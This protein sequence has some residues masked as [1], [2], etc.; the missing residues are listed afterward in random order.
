ME[1]DAVGDRY[2][3]GVRDDV[4]E[5]DAAGDRDGAGERDAARVRDDA[6]ERE[7]AGHADV[8]VSMVAVDAEHVDEVRATQVKVV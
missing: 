2:V 7:A 6:G 1:V 4:G 8:D 3:A 5:R